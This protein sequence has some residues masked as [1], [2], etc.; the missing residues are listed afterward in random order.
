MDYRGI[1]VSKKSWAVAFPVAKGYG[2][3]KYATDT[4][5]YEPLPGPLA[6]GSGCVLAATGPYQGR[7]ATYLPE[8]QVPLAVVNPLVIKH[9]SQM[10]LPRPKTDRAD[11]QLIAAYGEVEKPALWQPAA[12]FISELPPQSTGLEGLIPQRTA[13]KNQ[14]AACN[15]LPPVSP[16][17]A[18]GIRCGQRFRSKL[19][20][21]RE[22]W[23]RRRKKTR[24]RH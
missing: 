20:R 8:K 22:R 10:R 19:K 16:P 21:S 9:F 11:A 13:L 5:G 4:A 18:P 24:G 1:D 7:L 3:K 12:V 14:Q 23:R 6:A 2:V 17:A 15:Q